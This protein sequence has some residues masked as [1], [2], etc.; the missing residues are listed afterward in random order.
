MDSESIKSQKLCETRLD[1]VS[2]PES[3][4]RVF[5]P[6]T[7]PARA[8]FIGFSKDKVHLEFLDS[9]VKAVSKLQVKPKINILI[10]RTADYDAYETLKKYFDDSLYSFINLIPTSSIDTVWAQDYMEVLINTETGISE[11]IDLPYYG[12]EGDDIPFSVGLACQKTVHPQA[13]FEADFEPASGDY[14]GN[15]EPITAKVLTVGNNISDETLS[16][17]QNLTTQ[18]IIEV[19]VEWL[20]TGH[21][22]ELITTLPHKRNASPCEQTLLVS[23]PKLAFS[24]ISQTPKESEI[25]LNPNLPYYDEDNTWTDHYHCL[26]PS[27]QN[28]SECLELLTA[29]TVYQELIDVSVSKIQE[30]MQ[31]KHNCRLEISQF[32]QIFVPLNPRKLYGTYDDRAVAL[33][34]NSVNNIFFYPNLMLAKQEFP[35]FQKILDQTLKTF[36]YTLHYVDGKFVHE[37]NGGIHCATNISYGCSAL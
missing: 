37:L 1:N 18:D 19:N 16:S 15:I 20:E 14:G 5:L 6:R 7:Y 25:L 35:P 9:V 17:I 21:V 24:I 4:G 22:D 11:I 23:S 2:C 26:H 27:N 31:V 30:S 33:N 8:I 10:P 34:P 29:N 32:P 28:K 36:P 12:R 3:L 13:V